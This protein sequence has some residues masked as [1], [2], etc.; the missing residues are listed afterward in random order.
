MDWRQ[1]RVGRPD[2]G[3]VALR[4]PHRGRYRR[5]GLITSNA[6]STSSEQAVSPRHLPQPENK[7]KVAATNPKQKRS[8]TGALLSFI[9][10]GS[11]TA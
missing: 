9:N 8:L 1:R 11:V 3:R 6:G 2:P 4:C 10:S 5:D 7:T